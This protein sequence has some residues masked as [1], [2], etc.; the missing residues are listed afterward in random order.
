LPVGIHGNISVTQ[1][2][3]GTFE[4]QCYL[5]DADGRRREVCRRGASRSAAKTALIEAIGNR[6]AFGDSEITAESTL[7]ATAEAYFEQLERGVRDGQRS[8]N[9]LRIYRSVWANEVGI[10][11]G[12]LRVREATTSRLNAYLVSTRDRLKPDYRLSVKTVLTNVCA[13]A[14]RRGAI[15]TN[16]MRETEGIAREQKRVHALSVEQVTVWLKHLATDPIG[17]KYELFDFTLL[18]LATG[19]RISEVLAVLIEDVNLVDAS[20]RL[21][22]RIGR[23]TGQGLVRV[24]RRGGKGAGVTLHLPSWAVDTVR[25]RIVQLGEETGPLFP[26]IT[27]RWR[28]PKRIQVA[29]A[30]VRESAGMPDLTSHVFRKTVATLLDQAGLDVRDIATHLTHSSPKITES[31][32]IARK[33]RGKAGALAL[34]F[35]GD[36]AGSSTN[37]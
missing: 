9:T 10:S 24:P 26:G 8:Y 23:Q 3:K 33:A 37:K 30:Q 32:Y 34:E 27:V 19:A 21:D 7:T 2:R 16:P 14:V 36:L 1:I 35:L 31:H 11:V 4:A 5:R 13:L 17:V 6:P 12:K 18:M 28:D 15:P 20:V 22:H 29:I 25:R